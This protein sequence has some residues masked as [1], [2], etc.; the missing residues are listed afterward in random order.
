MH[1][2][3]SEFCK[4]LVQRGFVVTIFTSGIMPDS[5][6]NVFLEKFYSVKDFPVRFVCNVNEPSISPKTELE[7]VYRFFSSFGNKTSLSFNIYRMEF[8]MDFLIDYISQYGLDRHI[9]LGIAHPIPGEKNLYIPP[10]HFKK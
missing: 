1:P 5:K 6:Y 8:N 9:R 3:I 10:E 2:D 7:K 4:Y